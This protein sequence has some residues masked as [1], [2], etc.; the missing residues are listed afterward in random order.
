MRSRLALP[1][2]A[3]VLVLG[4]FFTPPPAAQQASARIVAVA[5]I[6]GAAAG[7]AQILRASG[8]I[9]A[10][11][12][13]VG[14]SARLVQ[15]GDM[16]DRGG[17]VR[18]VLDL[19]MRLEGEARRAGGRVDVLFG[20]HEGMNVLHDLRDVSADAFAAFADGR[21]EDRRRR[22]FDAHAAIAKRAGN[23]VDRETWIAAHPLGFVEYAEAF[24]PSGQYGR[25]LRGRKVILQIGDTLF[26]HAGLHPER[27]VTVEEVNRRVDDEV[28]KWDALVDALA[29][30]R[31]ATRFFTL[32]EIVSAAQVE[33]GR[34]GIAQKTGEGVAEHVTPEFIRLL[35]HL[36]MVDKWA[37]IDADGPLWYRG[38]ATLPD[39][40]QP[41]IDALLK[42]LGA[43]R[44]VIGH[45]P[46]LPGRIRTRFTGAV[47]LLD[48]GM[49]SR[50][51][52]GGQP[53]AL[54]IH[55]GRLTAIY[56]SGREPLDAT[57]AR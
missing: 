27:I 15:T 55:D 46:Q 52:K 54:E 3:F 30:A 17:D 42:R 39:D 34:I 43:R 40:Q 11:G 26:M 20:N 19:L 13:W 49:L 1:V 9:D 51:Y 29:R 21:S 23:V 57:A 25:W 37:L 47:V 50:Y 4:D 41:A 16:L 44:F 56:P 7:L 5:D 6:H 45:T 36:T 22:A 10:S 2:L 28:A 18:Q 33:I 38:L 24:G 8:L 14:G 32:P 35:Q 48:T 31:A 12:K 53:S